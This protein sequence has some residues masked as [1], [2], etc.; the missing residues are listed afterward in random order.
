[1][2]S[3]KRTLIMG[4]V[5]VLM[6]ASASDAPG[7]AREARK[8]S[9]LPPLVLPCVCE[10]GRWRS[11]SFVKCSVNGCNQRLQPILKVDPR[12]RDTWFHRECDVCHRPACEKHS[13]EEDRRIICDRCRREAEAPRP[14]E[15]LIDLGFRRGRMPS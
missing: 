6:H 7:V 11:M 10:F 14:S 15:G 5:L 1:V 12:D 8:L 13:M 3:D 2:T 4:L 9:K